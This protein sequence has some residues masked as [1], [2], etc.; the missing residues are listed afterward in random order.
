MKKSAVRPKKR[1]VGSPKRKL[2]GKLRFRRGYRL[3]KKAG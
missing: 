2:A 3:K 1:P